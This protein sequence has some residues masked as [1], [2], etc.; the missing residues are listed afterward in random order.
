MEKR[1]AKEKEKHRLARLSQVYMRVTLYFSLVFL[2][3]WNSVFLQV[4]TANP[5]RYSEFY[6]KTFK[7]CAAFQ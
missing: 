5:W 4:V 2:A 7:F 3:L 6:M 1:T